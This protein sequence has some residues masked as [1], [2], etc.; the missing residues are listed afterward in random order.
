[1]S[2]KNKIKLVSYLNEDI[3]IKNN[4]L[5]V[6]GIIEKMATNSDKGIYGSNV[7][8]IGYGS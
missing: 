7:L 5:T 1:M 3:A 2:R 6:E 4:Y 8:I